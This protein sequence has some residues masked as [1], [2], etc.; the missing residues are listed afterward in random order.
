MDDYQERYT[1]MSGEELLTLASQEATLVDSAQI[2][3]RAELS[4]RR[5]QNTSLSQYQEQAQKEIDT[6]IRTCAPVVE[7]NWVKVIVPRGSLRFPSVCPSCLGT[8]P[9]THVSIRSERENFAGYRVFY[10]KFK[11]LVITIP[12]CRFCAR[13]F[14]L[15]Q[16]ISGASIVVGILAAAAISEMFKPSSIADRKLLPGNMEKLTRSDIGEDQIRLR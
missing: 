13:R 16:R 5:L 1:K 6:A 4:R 14:V 8:N 10:T 7:G 2:A 3:L 15:W 12:H 11:Y 9:D